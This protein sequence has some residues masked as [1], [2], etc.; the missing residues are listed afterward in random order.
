MTI[1]TSLLAPAALL[2]LRRTLKG[3]MFTADQREYEHLRKVW[4]AAVDA[5][6][7]LIVQAED[8]A[9]AAHAVTFA[10]AQ[11]LLLAVR[12][13]GH[14]PAGFG[15]VNGGVLLDLSRMKG[16]DLDPETCQVRLESGLT[17]GEVADRMHPHGLA[18]TSG[19]VATVGVGGMTQG[20]GIG[21]FV[22]QHGLTI[23]RLK[24]VEL[25][26]AG[27][28][29]VRASAS[30]HP[31]LFWGLRGAGANFGVI[32]ALEFEAHQGGMVYGGLMAFDGSNPAELLAEYT[33]LSLEAPDFLTTEAMLMLAPPMPFLPPEAVGRPLLLV[34]ACYSG[35][36]EQGE[37]ALGPLRRLGTPLADLMGPLPYPALFK[38]S[39]MGEQRG[40]AHFTRSQFVNR[41][42]PAFFEALSQATLQVM[43]PG[44]MV[45]LR[46]LGGEMR[47]IPA[48]STAFA[49]RDHDLLLLVAHLIPDPATHTA[50]QSAN[51]HIFAAVRSVGAGAYGNY[52]G[53]NEEGR[54]SEVFPSTTFER[55][56]RLKAEWDVDNVFSRNVNV[57]PA[58][59]ERV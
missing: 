38:F 53:L 55:L 36:L 1:N 22:R 33:R 24:A 46:P 51:E 52:I 8:A 48:S 32:T 59:R 13:G 28:E 19:N 37:G 41:A 44:T 18:L 21:W 14:S 40:F 54:V 50:A 2:E 10:R 57:R 31:E 5:F 34:L 35:P 39:E 15:T 16:F 3:Q 17:W 42:T 58:P 47:R 9:D 20:G 27:G 29:I 30:E 23:D 49:G 25:V 7:A 11:N 6:P 12:S 56:T 43:N 4:N 26:T 45:Q